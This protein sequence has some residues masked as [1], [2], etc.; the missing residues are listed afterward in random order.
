MLFP[1]YHNQIVLPN[2]NKEIALL[3]GH[4]NDEEARGSLAKFLRYNPY[5]AVQLMTGLKLFPFQEMMIRAMFNKDF[6]LAIMGRGF[7]KCLDPNA[8]CMT[9]RGMMKFGDVQIGDYIFANKEPQLVTN[10]IVNELRDSI[11][12]T[13]GKGLVCHGVLEHKILVFNKSTLSFDYKNLKDCSMEEVI[14]LKLG[15]DYW[16]NCNILEGFFYSKKDSLMSFPKRFEIDKESLDLY[17]LLGLILSDGYISR[18]GF[19]QITSADKETLSFVDTQFKKISGSNV[20]NVCNK[21]SPALSKKIY[22]RQFVEF[23]RHLGFNYGKSHDK[24]IPEKI[25]RCSKPKIASFIKGM[26]DADGTVAIRKSRTSNEIIIGYSSSSKQIINVLQCVL[27][28]FGIMSKVV[29]SSKEG[30]CNFNGKIYKTKINYSLRIGDHYNLNIFH[31]EI[32]FLLK[33]K[34][35]RLLYYIKNVKP[36]HR[37]LFKT[38]YFIKKYGE[39]TYTKVI[40]RY[41]RKNALYRLDVIK[42][43]KSD[44]IDKNDKIKL[45]TI[46]ESNYYFDTVKSIEKD[47]CITIDCT[48]DKEECYWANGFINHNTWSAA[49]FAWLYAVMVPDSK[50]GI[51]SKSFRQARFIFQYIEEFAGGRDGA[52]LQQCFG[53]KP[54]HKNDIWEM[55]IG[56][57]KIV[58]LPLGEGGKLRGFRFNVILIDELLLMPENVINEVILPFISVNFDPQKRKE[59]QDRE[60]KAIREGLMT[61]DERTVFPNPKFIGLS[62]ASYKF[63]FLYKL[64]IEYF[65][66]ITS[67]EPRNEKGELIN[68]KGYG[69][70]Q[71]AYDVAPEHIYNKDTLSKFKSQMSEAQF[72][73]EFG[74][75]FTDDSGGFFSKRKMD[76]CTKQIGQE[77]TI[78]IAGE[79]GY[80]YILAIDP[81]FSKSESSDHYAMGLFKLDESD[82]KNR[83]ATLVHNYAVAGG[84]LQDHMRYFTYL[85]KHF[86]IVYII[87]DNAGHWFIDECNASTIFAEAKLKLDFFDADFENPD[88]MKGLSNSKDSYNLQSGKI[89][90]AQKFNPEWIRIAN[91]RLAAAFDHQNIWFAAAPD[92]EKYTQLKNVNIPLEPLVYDNQGEQLE[93]AAKKADFIEHQTYLIDLVKSETALIEI[94][95]SAT[96]NQTFQLPQNLRRSDSADRTRRDNY[97][98]LLMGN[99]AIRCYY[100]ITYVDLQEAP[101][102]LPFFI[103]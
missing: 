17:Y 12:L 102:F 93:G 22:S 25:L 20:Q 88:Y 71:L 36:K 62:S 78:E 61:D 49:M 5:I 45:Q 72:Q 95:S 60:D 97:T 24:V 79:K 33:R 84:H 75:I 69:I 74:A 101:A 19:I 98:T 77:P 90:H 37:L 23:L 81:S 32:G 13:S 18:A 43:L 6:F 51:I 68:S 4:L 100:D 9:N 30:A 103:K 2:V 40:G 47:K 50:I 65:N 10:K 7:S 73:R 91:E 89:C 55:E 46:L 56:T 86:N 3:K 85:L 31:K 87:I 8:L 99:H 83:K 1:G 29:I 14:P 54:S 11:K 34:N 63:E 26:M 15:T 82:P 41:C 35:D 39:K 70:M 67:K 76:L 44:I 64:Y 16:G 58:A 92:A 96:G 28:N 94:K 57:S 21:N 38:D 66:K 27:L 59:V 42:L 52:L 53:G 48:V 80:K